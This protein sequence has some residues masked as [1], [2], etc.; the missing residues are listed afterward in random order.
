[1]LLPIIACGAGLQ[2]HFKNEGQSYKYTKYIA[3][4]L[5]T[6]FR[7]D[8]IFSDRISKLSKLKEYKHLNYNSKLSK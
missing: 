1:M 2:R 4:M 3:K 5:K 8:L 7:A 6:V